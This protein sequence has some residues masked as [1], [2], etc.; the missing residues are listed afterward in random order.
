MD[1]GKVNLMRRLHQEG[2]KIA[3]VT[4]SIRETAH[5]MLKRSG[6]VDY[7]D[8]IVTNEDINNPKPHPEGY[9][10]AMVILNSPPEMAVIVED[11]PKGIQAAEMTGAKVVKVL[12][13]TE[14]N[15][16]IIL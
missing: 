9:I 14:V 3:C 8:C 4:N 1:D 15:E 11:S 12:N 6:V 16:N 2:F 13:A 10:K 5:L 7:M